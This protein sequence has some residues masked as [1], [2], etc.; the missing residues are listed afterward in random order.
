MTT[1]RDM[2]SL[3]TP[4]PAIDRD[5]FGRPMVT[6]PSGKGKIAYT[7][8]TTFIDCIGDKFNLQQWEKRMV[9]IGLS[10]RADLLLSVTAH[11]DDKAELNRICDAAKEAAA[12]SSSATTG[13]ALH[14][15]AELVDRGQL[16]PV[17]PD[18]A[19]ADIEAY[20]AATTDLSAVHIEQ[21]MVQDPLKIGGTPDRVV[22]YDGKTY[23]ADIKTGGI[24]YDPGKIA[25]QLAIYARSQV[26][27]IATGERSR[28]NAD[29]DRGIVIH[30]PAGEAKCDLW[31]IDLQRGWQDVLLARNIREAR[32]KKFNDL[33]SP[34][35][36]DLEVSLLDSIKAEID[37]ALDPDAIRALWRPD[38]SKDL[39][40]YAR[41][42]VDSLLASVS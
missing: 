38:W 15:L 39:T 30:L 14:A 12:A 33:C 19:K 2:S 31:F 40:D 22:K 21:F 29:L 6:P 35:G 13:T 41:A 28:H 37:K 4:P 7:R 27:D 9:A 36:P 10:Q 3:V 5:R 32:K 34:F 42:R 8:A 20:Q 16:L 18:S 23:I 17:V 24:S 26:Y 11:L 25:A 1:V